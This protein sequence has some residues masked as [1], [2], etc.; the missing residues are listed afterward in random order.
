LLSP[1]AAPGAW[2]Q[3]VRQLTRRPYQWARLATGPRR[4]IEDKSAYLRRCSIAGGAIHS[5]P[6]ALEPGPAGL[7]GL[8][9]RWV[10]EPTLEPIRLHDPSPAISSKELSR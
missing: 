4:R 2:A 3:L 6:V 5:V 9:A 10:P 1:V 8:W 7:W